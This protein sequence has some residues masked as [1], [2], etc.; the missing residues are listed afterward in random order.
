MRGGIVHNGFM[1]LDPD[2]C[3][4]AVTSRDPR[5]DGR[6]FV[7]VTSTRIYCRPICRV[8]IPM[9]K[10]CRF[11]RSAAAAEAAG[12]RPCLR[13]RPELAPGNAS[14]D[15]NARLAQAAVHLMENEAL[16]GGGIAQLASRLGVTDRHLRR[17]FESEFGVPPI[18]FLQTQ[19]LLLA[20]HLLVDTR[21][22]VTEVALASGFHSVRRFNALLKERYRCTPRRLR[23]ATAQFDRP[24]ALLFKLAYRPPY[25]W[26][27]MVRFLADRAIEG[28]EVVEENHYRRSVRLLHSGKQ[29]QGWIDITPALRGSAFKVN[30]STSLA[31]VIPVILSRVRQFMD[32]S[33]NPAE[34]AEVLGPLATKNQGLRIPGTLDGFELGV[35]AVLGQQIT[36]RAA[37]TLIGRFAG[38]F[39]DRVQ[40]P[41]T[42]VNTLFPVPEQVLAHPVRSIVELGVVT[43]R[44]EA[45]YAFA[46][47]LA[48]GSIDLRPGAEVEATLAKLKA[49]PGFGE[50][51][52]QYIAMRALAWPDAFVHPDNAVLKALGE[53]SP[54]QARSLSENWRPWRAYAV[55]HLWHSLR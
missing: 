16:N 35:R 21:L 53:S 8:K 36:V 13:C 52:A 54:K 4:H 33:C 42:T 51:T 50:W 29:H 46:K 37:R 12:F 30:I 9:Q 31:K 19:R 34:I 10:N 18:A 17:V 40:T 2:I 26:A 23:V 11:Y 15:A 39:G 55:M 47:A 24:D 28:V 14:V 43:A 38:K 6:F 48:D 7:G 49:L 41:F 44:A 20:K 3:Y 45:I 25:D 1:E 5:F 22:P 27:A 32:L